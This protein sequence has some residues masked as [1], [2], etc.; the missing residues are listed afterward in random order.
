MAEHRD[1]D[2]FSWRYKPARLE[3]LKKYGDPYW[4]KSMI[5]VCYKGIP[6]DTYW[7]DGA[8][9]RAIHEDDVDLVLLGNLNDCTKIQAY[10]LPYYDS[11]DVID[12]R[13]PNSSSAPIYLKNGAKRSRDAMLEYAT[14]K[15]ERA[16][17]DLQSAVSAIERWNAVIKQ[18]ESGEIDGVWL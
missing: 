1:G 10:D 8:D 3:T 2:I 17:S 11:A 6:F 18:I 16:Q 15:A 12:M 14:Y 9:G 7:G 13:H 5:A 4:C